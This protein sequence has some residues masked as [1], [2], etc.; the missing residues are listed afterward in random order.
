MLWSKQDLNHQD[1]RT[2]DY[3][4]IGDI[5]VWPDILTDIEL[6]KI[7]HVACEHSIPEIAQRAPENQRQRESGA[8]QSVRVSPQQSRHDYERQQREEDQE[9]NAQLRWSVGEQS[10]GGAAVGDVGELEKPGNDLDAVMKRNRPGDDPLAEP[11]EREYDSGDQ[12]NIF[13]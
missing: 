4:A 3:G 10:K 2:N 9:Y 11:V 8:I 1:G 13:S 5:E 7:D 12:Q 6:K